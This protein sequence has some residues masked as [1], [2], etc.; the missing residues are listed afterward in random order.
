MKFDVKFGSKQLA[1]EL[2]DGVESAPTLGE[3]RR[4]LAQLT[5]VPVANQKLLGKPNLQ[6]KPDDTLLTAAG[7]RTGTTNRIML[8]GST[9]AQQERADVVVAE[10]DDNQKVEEEKRLLRRYARN[11]W[12]IE[13]Y[14]H[15]LADPFLAGRSSGLEQASV[16]ISLISLNQ[17]LH[18]VNP[19]GPCYDRAHATRSGSASVPEGSPSLLNLSR[20]LLQPLLT[21]ASR[22]AALRLAHGVVHRCST[23]TLTAVQAT[24]PQE[25]WDVVQSCVQR[26]ESLSQGEYEMLPSGWCGR[27]TNN[28]LFLLVTRGERDRFTMAVVNRGAGGAKYHRQW[29]TVDKVKTS[30]VIVLR[31]IAKDKMLDK[32]FWLLLLSLW[33]RANDPQNRSEYIRPEVF[34]EVLLP[35]LVERKDGPQVE[36]S[37]AALQE[38]VWGYTSAVTQEHTA[39]VNTIIPSNDHGE[40][41]TRFLDTAGATPLRGGSST[42]KSAVTALC[43]LV[44]ELSGDGVLAHNM[45]QLKFALKLESFIRAAEDLVMCGRLV[46]PKQNWLPVNAASAL[47]TSSGESGGDAKRFRVGSEPYEKL[48]AALEVLE[49]TGVEDAAKNALKLEDIVKVAVEHKV[50]VTNSSGVLLNWSHFEKKILLVYVAALESGA[51]RTSDMLAAAAAKLK[52]SASIAEVLFVS[53]DRSREAYDEHCK[54][55][56]FTR[57]TFPGLSLATA[58]DLTEPLELLVF[59]PSGRLVH[60]NG[61]AALRDDPEA[62]TFPTGPL[63]RGVPYLNN[64]DMELLTAGSAVLSHHVQKRMQSSML[65]PAEANKVLELLDAVKIVAAEMPQRAVASL[66][67]AASMQERQPTQAQGDKEYPETEPEHWASSMLG[68]AAL[69]DSVAAGIRGEDGGYHNAGLLPL[70]NTAAHLGKPYTATVPLLRSV[71]SWQRATNLASLHQLLTTASGTIKKLWK[72]AGNTSTASRVAEQMHII[73]LITWMTVHLLPLPRCPGSEAPDEAPATADFYT[74]DTFTPLE[75]PTATATAAGNVADSDAGAAPPPLFDARGRGRGR[76]AGQ[77]E[78]EAEATPRDMQFEI[79]ESLFYLT[80]SLANAWQAVETPQRSFD[81]ERCLTAMHLLLIFDAV[82]RC[83]RGSNRCQILSKMLNLDGGYFLSTSLG[84]QNTPFEKVS[85][86]L[87]LTRPGMLPIRSAALRYI[88]HAASTFREEL[89][90]LPMPSTAMLEVR[91]SSPTITFFRLFHDYAGIPLVED[92]PQAV[93]QMER[94]MEAF[95]GNTAIS[96]KHPEFFLLR[97]MVFLTKM[98]GTMETRDTY[99]LHR[100][101]ELGA[102]THWMFSFEESTPGRRMSAGWRTNPTPP[103]WECVLVRGRSMDIADVKVEGFGGR[104]LHFGEGLALHSPIDVGRLMASSRVTEEDILHASRLPTFGGSLSQEEAETL[105]SLLTTPYLRIP[106][107][108]DFFASGDRSSHLLVK[109]VQDVLRAALFEPAAYAPNSKE[110]EALD[111]ATASI[112]LSRQD[113]LFIDRPLDELPARQSYLTTKYG[114]LLNELAH[115]PHAVLGALA[116]LLQ[117]TETIGGSSAYSIAASYILFLVEVVCDVLSFAQFAC[118]MEAVPEASKTI[119]RQ[120]SAEILAFLEGTMYP[121]FEGWI[122]ESE[123]NDDTPTHCAVRNCR[124]RRRDHLLHLLQSCAFVRSHHGFGM[125]LQRTQLTVQQG[126]ELLTPEESLMRFLQAQGLRTPNTQPPA[127]LS[128]VKSLMFGGGRRRAVFL[129]IT[130]GQH[131]DTVRL[132]NLFRSNPL[133]TQDAKRRKLPPCDVAENR[134][135]LYLLDS[136]RSIIE[137]LR[138]LPSTAL[139]RTMEDVVAVVLQQPCRTPPPEARDGRWMLS[140]ASDAV[141]GPPSSGLVF[142]LQ[143]GELFWRHQSLRPVPDTMSHLTDYENILGREPRQ[144]GEVMRH[145][146]RHWVHVVGTPYDLMEWSPPEPAENRHGERCPVIIGGDWPN[147]E[148]LGVL[149]EGVVFDRLVGV[150]PEASE[151]PWPVPSERW[152]VDLLR[153]V[154]PAALLQAPPVTTAEG[155]H[156]G[157]LMRFL[158]NDGTAFPDNLEQA[159][160]KEFVAVKDPVPYIEVYNLLSHGRRMYRSLIYTT[161]QRLS[162]HSMALLQA[163]VKEDTVQLRAFEAGIITARI[164]CESSLEIHRFNAELRGREMYLPPRLLQGVLPGTLLEAFAF[165]QGEDDII[166]GYISEKVSA[167]TPV[168]Q[169]DAGNNDTAAAGPSFDS[170]YNYSLEIVLRSGRAYVVRR[171]DRFYTPI[172]A[173]G[174]NESAEGTPDHPELFRD[175]ALLRTTTRESVAVCR[176]VLENVGGDVTAALAWMTDAMNAEELAALRAADGATERQ[177]HKDPHQMGP[178][179]TGM[180]QKMRVRPED[181]LLL[182]VRRCLALHQLFSLLCG[183][184]DASHILIWGHR[185]A[186]AE[187]AEAEGLVTAVSDMEGLFRISSIEMPRLHAKFLVQHE[188][189]VS[190]APLHFFLADYPGWRLAEPEDLHRSTL[191]KLKALRDTFQQS[192]VVCNAVHEVAVL[193]PNHKFHPVDVADDP[194]SH[195]L[196]FDRADFSWQTVPSPFYLYSLHASGA[197]IVPQTLAASLYLAALQCATGHYAMALTTLES[198]YSDTA[199]THEELFMADMMQFTCWDQFPDAVAVRLKMAHAVQ[200]SPNNFE[201]LHLAVELNTY[202]SVVQHVSADCRL[203]FTEVLDLLKRC[204]EPSTLIRTQVELHAARIH[205]LKTKGD[206]WPASLHTD[207]MGPETFPPDIIWK[208]LVL[209][210]W[211]RITPQKPRRIT[212]VSPTGLDKIEG[213]IKFIWEDRLLVDEESGSNARLGF[214]FLYNLHVGLHHIKV[215]DYDAT[216][217]FTALL[218]RWFHLRHAKW[219]REHHEEGESLSGPSWCAAV[220]QL[221]ALCP[222]AGWPK[223]NL[224]R[225]AFELRRGISIADVVQENRGDQWRVR[226]SAIPG[227]MKQVDEIARDCWQ[228]N[229]RVV[230]LRHE[231]EAMYASLTAKKVMVRVP[232]RSTASQL[233]GRVEHNDTAQNSVL[234]SATAGGVAATTLAALCNQPLLEV[235]TL[236]ELVGALAGETSGSPPEGEPEATPPVALPFNLRGHPLA[237]SSIATAMLERLEGDLRLYTA[238]QRLAQRRF[239]LS[240]LSAET[241]EVLLLGDDAAAFTAAYMGAEAALN[242]AMDALRALRRADQD[243]VEQLTSAVLA[244]ANSVS[245][246]TGAGEDL[247]R[248]RLMLLHR[249]RMP[250]RMEW[251]CGGLLSTTLEDEVRRQNP[252]HGPVEVLRSHVALLM[253]CSNRSHLA[254][255]TVAVLQQV[256]LFLQLCRLLRGVSDEAVHVDA[257]AQEVSPA[258]R[259]RELHAL[260]ALEISPAELEEVLQLSAARDDPCLAELPPPV[261]RLLQQRLHHLVR[262]AQELLCARRCYVDPAPCEEEEEEGGAHGAAYRLD[263]RFLIMEFL[264]HI[265]LRPRQVEMTRWFVAELQAGRSRVQQMIMGQ[266]KTSVVAPLLTLILADGKQLVTQVMPTALVEQTRAVLRRCFGVVIVK[267][268]FTLQFDRSRAEDGVGG[269]W[270]VEGLLVKLERAVVDRAVVVAAPEC[271]KSL[272]LKYIEQLHLLES[273]KEVAG[274]GADERRLGLISR[275]QRREVAR[276]HLVDAIAPILALWQDGVLLMDEVD[277][278]LHPLR[279]ELNFP[280][281]EKD[282]IDLSGPRWELPIHLLDL[283][284]AFRRSAEQGGGGDEDVLYTQRKFGKS[285]E[286]RSQRRRLLVEAGTPQEALPPALDDGVLGERLRSVRSALHAALTEGLARHALQR[287]PH[288]VLL[289]AAF[290]KTSLLPHFVTWAQLWVF[291][292]LHTYLSTNVLTCSAPW[293]SF[294]AMADFTMPFFSCAERC[295][296]ANAAVV[297]EILAATPAYGVKLLN[298]AHD[299]LHRLLPHVLAKIDRVSY[300]ILQPRDTERYSKE[301]LQFMPLSR[302]LTAVPFVAKDVPSASS[303]FAHPDVAIGLTVLAFRYEGLRRRDT[304]RLLQGLKRDLMKQRGPKDQRPAELLYQEWVRRGME[305]RRAET[306]GPA[307]LPEVVPLAQ[308]QTSDVFQLQALHSL[309]RCIPDVVYH[310]LSSHVFPRTM[311]FHRL[312][313]SACGHEL[314]SSMLFGR[315]L[316]FSGTPSNLL[317]VDLGACEYESGSDARVLSVL[318]DPEVVSSQTI[319]DDWTPLK[320]LDRIAKA[321]PPFY[322]LIDAGA[323]ITNMNNS[324]VAVYLLARLP[325]YLFD[326]VVY[327]DDRDQ[328]MVLQRSNGIAVPVAQC[329]IPI[330][331][332]F[333]FFDQVHTTGTDVKQVASATAVMTLG[334]DLTF[335]DYAQAAYRMRGLGKGQRLCLYLIPEVVARMRSML[336]VE[337]GSSFETGDTL[338]DVPAWL[339]LNSMKIETLQLL[340]LSLQELSNVWRK[341]AYRFFLADC[342]T[343]AQHPDIFTDLMRGAMFRIDRRTIRGAPATSMIRTFT[344][345]LLPLPTL[346]QMREAIEEFREAVAYPVAETIETPRHFQSQVDELLA[347]RPALLAPGSTA[348]AAAAA[349]V[350]DVVR[351]FNFGDRAAAGAAN[352]FSDMLLNAEI[353]HEQEAEEEQQQEAEEEQQRITAFSRDDEKPLPWRLETLQR[354][355]TDADASTRPTDGSCFYPMRHFTVH[356]NP[357]GVRLARLDARFMLSDNYFRLEWSGLGE[358]RLRNAVLYLDWVP[359]GAAAPCHGLV[360]LVEGESLRWLLHRCGEAVARTMKATLRLVSDGSSVSSAERPVRGALPPEPSLLFRFVNNE[361]FFSKEHLEVLSTRVLRSVPPGDRLQ[362]F[363][364]CLHCRRRQTLRWEDTPVAALFFTP[365]EEPYRPQITLFMQLQAA[366]EALVERCTA[367]AVDHFEGRSGEEDDLPTAAVEQF[368]AAALDTAAA[369]AAGSS[370][371]EPEKMPIPLGPLVALLQQYFPSEMGAMSPTQLAEGISYAHWKEVRCTAG[372]EASSLRSVPRAEVLAFTA[373]A[374]GIPLEILYRLLPLSPT[375]VHDHIALRLA[376]LGAA[377]A[378]E[379][380]P[381]SC[382][383]CTLQNAAGLHCCAA[384]GCLRAQKADSTVD[385]PWACE[386]CTFINESRRQPLCSVCLAPNPRVL[387]DTP[388]VGAGPDGAGLQSFSRVPEG[389]WECMVEYGGCTKLNTNDQFYC[390]ACNSGRPNLSNVRF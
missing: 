46:C 224:E 281:G 226:T 334:K 212:Y 333:A 315:R 104:D 58:L 356:M 390:T 300:G 74:E 290:Y 172:A 19:L 136:Y 200:H 301:A 48:A 273:T 359:D 250:L 82:A 303:E 325:H 175:V 96:L 378:A 130:T 355:T 135:F 241:V 189:G 323:L 311:L 113:E 239:D 344:G 203:A 81:S 53:L 338:R 363:K 312:K 276:S 237:G 362:F 261:S 249:D 256:Q 232:L 308:V 143:T 180:D 107:I 94:L 110:S 352:T 17:L 45:K 313:I 49:R 368:H 244:L 259:A 385:G 215:K 280:I 167:A 131:K 274:R 122:A 51:R 117:Q 92:G 26:L 85:A 168:S 196:R 193:V 283:I 350:A 10:A 209:H 87:E 148:I 360:S 86:A 365:E 100:R 302:Q 268:V 3:L 251:L 18:R 258:Q 373:T 375:H 181:Q 120:D 309:F 41:Y 287:E 184:E 389:Y 64:T 97:D 142:H 370:R 65:T 40:R 291:D 354:C 179:H 43:W 217:T 366:T 306:A 353:V 145:R 246:G 266:G 13:S 282:P 161:N 379:E 297:G 4:Q 229:E 115:G 292:E 318:T 335:R 129:Q 341:R 264:F 112:P 101:K 61:L 279:S 132:P 69:R 339:M 388:T 29:Q 222:E 233:Q 126:D 171:D 265:L 304:K 147:S 114:L 125:G 248:H 204:S 138:T 35:W 382:P 166:R 54:M 178:Q 295:G 56:P 346:E 191:A 357:P 380:G 156:E 253:L 12:R 105:L 188:G 347:H 208:R 103:Q 293:W 146:H 150:G 15:L 230:K 80:L 348:D 284:C 185:V 165:W 162:L 139:S 277:V 206:T 310:Y 331:R 243:T 343:A 269:S 84:V 163:T 83:E 124:D 153:S 170:R 60:R 320:V 345:E 102:F 252:F 16:V 263:P 235:L 242:A 155:T 176:A 207:I 225:E 275:A 387:D 319:E 111:L 154:F 192:L 89:F 326:G 299:W 76:R 157:G 70:S 386:T 371:A 169:H 234:L 7:F 245:D 151:T 231:R 47:Q 199:F 55:M 216:S 106:L 34:Y 71:Y 27:Q 68:G 267:H 62:S 324:D 220:L 20:R 271:I 322:A 133:D 93:T 99:L 272:F 149:W 14:T 57:A 39:G 236:R 381:W 127:L 270:E 221:M 384:C 44:D 42:I 134:V 75:N 358:R 72:R 228:N 36:G 260:F 328:Q 37:P 374:G 79:L 332:R 278:L 22:C 190:S 91:Y 5:G 377:N 23:F 116:H 11:G 173:V 201:W 218:S 367:R 30:P 52:E 321:Q 177:M 187:D 195:N 90:H 254:M 342:L 383:T 285:A 31:D 213:I 262:S 160:W 255:Q 317:P 361:M 349:V 98:L 63:W 66:Y 307:L 128:Q 247:T 289:D 33:M 109:E 67:N 337:D 351:R 118:G 121:R 50:Y 330:S 123:A 137:G 182:S 8:M 1:L 186:P 88:R 314:G 9:A 78:A 174:E 6:A 372:G 210:P 329:G 364:D 336:R 286:A 198:C 25:I 316:G 298:L 296:E 73:E 257:G 144:C 288:L 183:L 238:Q 119:I 24:S 376:T 152:A 108:L 158:L 95:C 59:A 159:T 211:D 28:M 21:D 2:A 240:C 340:K 219:G 38:L 369:A 141:V 214:F 205:H 227:L 194:F 305:L 32:T 223:A 164:R 202:L 140:L 327:L 77:A 197:F 294:D